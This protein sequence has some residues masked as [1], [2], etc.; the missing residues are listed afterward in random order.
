MK[1]KPHPAEDQSIRN[2]VSTLNKDFAA[3]SINFPA[4]QQR[5]IIYS[6]QSK[7]RESHATSTFLDEEGAVELPMNN[8]EEQAPV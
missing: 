3:S 5:M 6:L 1:R 2:T 7:H 4:G 8:N